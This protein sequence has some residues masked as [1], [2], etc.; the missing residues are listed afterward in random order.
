MSAQTSAIA[1]EY[2][3]DKQ[4]IWLL[5]YVVA[6]LPEKDSP[7]YLRLLGFTS[8]RF[9]K[10][11]LQDLNRFL[12]ASLIIRGGE[13]LWDSQSRRLIEIVS[14]IAIE[15]R[16]LQQLILTHVSLRLLFERDTLVGLATNASLSPETL[17]SLADYLSSNAGPLMMMSAEQRHAF[18]FSPIFNW[19][20]VSEDLTWNAFVHRLRTEIH[21][22]DDAQT[23]IADNAEYG[24][25]DPYH[26]YQTL[27]E[28]DVPVKS[29]LMQFDPNVRRRASTAS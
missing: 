20:S 29:L 27:L 2:R 3:H 6:A 4:A 13:T 18:L 17:A 28:M 14:H 23:L 11:S 19:I 5:D 16:D 1:K 24:L 9:S 15:L 26:L 10:I 25:V 12:Q 7:Q 8:Y 21:T 22:L